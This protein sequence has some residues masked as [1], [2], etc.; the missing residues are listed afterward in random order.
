MIFLEFVINLNQFH[1]KHVIK[2]NQ[3][4]NITDITHIFYGYI[5]FNTQAY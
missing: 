5:E 4:I 2:L 3:I 1:L